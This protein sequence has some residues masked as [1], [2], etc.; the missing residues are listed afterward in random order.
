MPPPG[1]ARRRKA[2]PPVGRIVDDSGRYTYR[3]VHDH[4]TPCPA[5]SLSLVPPS[6]HPHQRHTFPNCPGFP[7]VLFVSHPK[8]SRVTHYSLL[9]AYRPSPSPPS[10]PV[11][12]ANFVRNARSP[13]QAP[14]ANPLPSL[15]VPTASSA[16]NL[17]V[18][19]P[20]PP[21][22]R[23]PY[24]VYH[25]QPSTDQSQGG[26]ALS[27]LPP[28]L[29]SSTRSSHPPSRSR[30]CRSAIDVAVPSPVPRRTRPPGPRRHGF[31]YL[32]RLHQ[33]PGL[34]SPR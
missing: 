5:S 23:M 27:S 18:G 26:A 28:H 11:V 20:P 25:S 9:I 34:E 22:Q 17:D 30:T 24:I 33:L 29:F 8:A 7:S 31:E 21:F 1:N 3:L 14:T 2:R 6:T 15:P 16:A 13:A 4:T 19:L 12:I 10:P 32:P